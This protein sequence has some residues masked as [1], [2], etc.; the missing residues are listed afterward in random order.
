M[1]INSFYISI[2]DHVAYIVRIFHAILQYFIAFSS[3][4]VNCVKSGGIGGGGTAYGATKGNGGG[5]I[6]GGGGNIEAKT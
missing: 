4:S 5:I 6:K 2:L 1:Y 3:S